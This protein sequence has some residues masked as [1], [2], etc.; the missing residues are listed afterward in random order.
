M[1]RAR[2]Q[3]H[4]QQLTDARGSRCR[5]EHHDGDAIRVLGHLDEAA[6]HHTELEPFLGYLLLEGAVGELILVDETSG[7]F[8]ARR[9]VKP[10][11][12]RLRSE[13]R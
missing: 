4:Q 13:R 11:V 10:S 6:P 1:K 8:V 2:G 5:V 3:S 12:S 7:E 9:A